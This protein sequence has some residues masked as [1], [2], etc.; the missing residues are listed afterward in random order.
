MRPLTEA[1]WQRLAPILDE[2]LDLDPRGRSD[3][4]DRVCAGDADLRSEAEVLLAADAA[5]GEFLETPPEAY[6]AGLP[7]LFPAEPSTDVGLPAAR[8][9]P[10]SLSGHPRSL[11]V[12][13]WARSTSPSA[14]TASSSSASRSSS[15][16]AGSTP[17]EVRRRFLAERQIL[18]RL[19][20]PHIARLL[21]GGVTADGQPWFAMEYVD[22]E[23][24]H[25][26][27]RRAAA[28]DRR[29]APAVSPPSARRCSTPT[30]TWSCTATSSRR[31]FSSRPTVDVKLLDFGI[32]KLLETG[33]AGCDRYRAPRPAP[34]CGSDAGVRRARADPRRAGDHRDRRLRARRSA[35]RAADRPPGAPVRASHPRRGRA[36][37]LRHRARSAQRRGRR[38]RPTAP[39]L[40]R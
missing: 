39:D 1:R 17:S 6:L 23:S 36:G 33:A 29:A 5:S 10:G 19:S 27:L 34:S 32:A 4:L 14:P 40:T 7:G 25:R 28:R 30:R 18:A 2:A 37:C 8:N 15:S 16:G 21:D 22:G 20:H 26:V 13:A 12:A 31:T 3:Y 35:L 38:G 11:P 24:A 9:R